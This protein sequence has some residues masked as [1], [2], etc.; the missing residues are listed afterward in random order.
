MGS[1]QGDW[2]Y[3]CFHEVLQNH[4]Y[5]VKGNDQFFMPKIVAIFVDRW[6]KICENKGFIFHFS[7]AFMG[8]SFTHFRQ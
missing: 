5:S 3:V 2:L 4:K 6:L 1:Q 8:K 7:G